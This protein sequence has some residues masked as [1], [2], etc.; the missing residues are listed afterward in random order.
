VKLTR[1]ILFLVVLFIFFFKGNAQL[2]D[3]FKVIIKSKSSLDLRIESR[4]SFID[5]SLA[6]M[7]GV[8][9]GVSY[10]RK[11]KLGCGVSWLNSDIKNSDYTLSETGILIYTPKYL[12]LAY[13]ALYADFVFYKTQRW[14]LSVPLQTGFG[15]SWFQSSYQFSMDKNKKYFLML[16]EPGISTQFKIFKFLGLGVDVGYRFAA[17]NNNSVGSRFSSPTYAFKIMFWA[18]QLFYEVFPKSK[19]TEKYGPS[20]W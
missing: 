15:A 9:V 10:R 4:Y 12:K 11:L 14:Q 16:Y 19:L 13:F 6:R 17:K 3:S 20:V 5:N 8:R 7:L 1:H 18:D 2:L